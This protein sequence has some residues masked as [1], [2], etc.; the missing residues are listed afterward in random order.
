V[1][2]FDCHCSFGIFQCR[3]CQMLFLSVLTDGILEVE[4]VS[5]DLSPGNRTSLWYALYMYMLQCFSYTKISVFQF[6]SHTKISD[7]SVLQS[8]KNFQCFSA[9]IAHPN[10]RCL[11][12]NNDIILQE[13]IGHTQALP[14]YNISV[15]HHQ[16]LYRQ[17]LY[18][19]SV[20][21]CQIDSLQ[22]ELS[23]APMAEGC[24]GA[25]TRPAELQ[26]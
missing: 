23:A 3:P 26:G 4:V 24:R 22:A 25:L 1:G 17:F 11:L 6:F 9:S 18:N 5:C 19:Y 8:Y 13:I 2:N 21:Y 16:K 7:A 10:F 12:H 15:I 20:L 14:L